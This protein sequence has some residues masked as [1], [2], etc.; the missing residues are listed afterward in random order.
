M[1]TLLFSGTGMPITIKTLQWLQANTMN[2]VNALAREKEDYTVLWGIEHDPTHNDL[3]EGAFLWQGQIIP[4]RAGTFG[5][6][7]TIT[8]VIEN[9]MY[10]T[11]PDNISEMA[12]LPMY[13]EKYASV[14]TGG[15]HTFDTSLLKYYIQERVIAR[16]VVS[17]ENFMWL[18]EGFNGAI[19]DVTFP[20]IS[21]NYRIEYTLRTQGEVS[22]TRTHSTMIIDSTVGNFR[23]AINGA[24]M[25]NRTYSLEWKI[26]K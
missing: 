8:D 24:K 16:G 17:D 19:V 18:G 22:T 6:T 13:R 14:G 2:I 5:E 21:G 12:S 23:V 3:S 7:I 25:E 9:E 15:S 11:N 10:N 4:F 26:I 1:K 20:T